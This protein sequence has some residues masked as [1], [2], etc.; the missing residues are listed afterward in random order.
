MSRK[1]ALVTTS[2]TTPIAVAGPS[3]RPMN[4]SMA[5]GI[6]ELVRPGGKVWSPRTP[7]RDSERKGG[8][9]DDRWPHE[10]QFDVQQRSGT[11][12][13]ECAGRFDEP[14]VDTFE[15]GRDRPNHERVARD[16]VGGD[17]GEA[18]ADGETS[19]ADFDAED[20]ASEQ[21]E[22]DDDARHGQRGHRHGVDE[23]PTAVVPGREDGHDDAHRQGNGERGDP[24]QQ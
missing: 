14:V 11:R 20:E 4:R 23:L 3:R 8:P 22:A 6:A 12:R 10:R 17:D 19:P 13:A 15:A 21:A 24:E 18:A 9:S 16:S 2:K 5:I 7:R 1:L